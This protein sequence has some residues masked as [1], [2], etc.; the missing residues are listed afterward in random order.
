MKELMVGTFLSRIP[1]Y[2]V[3]LAPAILNI[4]ALKTSELLSRGV[5]HTEKV[6]G[7]SKVLTTLTITL[8]SV[9]VSMETSQA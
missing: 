2:N 4:S 8:V 3:V 5:P 6:M 1:M 9:L 7:R